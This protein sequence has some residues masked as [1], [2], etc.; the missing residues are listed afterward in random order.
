MM[1]EIKEAHIFH[2]TQERIV[3]IVLMVVYVAVQA[4]SLYVGIYE[5]LDEAGAREVFNNLAVIS[6][7]ISFFVACLFLF[8]LWIESFMCF[9]IAKM[10][11]PLWRVGMYE[12]F[13]WVLLGRLPFLLVLLGV[14]IE[15]N[16]EMSIPDVLSTLVNSLMYI[17]YGCCL[18]KIGKATLRYSL[19]TTFLMVC[20]YVSFD[21]LMGAVVA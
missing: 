15:G 12:S 7:V 2:E 16:N 3:G 6:G 1:G 20:I 8:S 11:H 21:L 13:L 17:F 19:L 10:A 5:E 9:V 4:F 18:W 14:V